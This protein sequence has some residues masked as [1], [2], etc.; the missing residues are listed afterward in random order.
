MNYRFIG[1]S[2]EIAG[3]AALRLYGQSVELPDGVARDAI[4]GGCAL[5]PDRD[6]TELGFTPEELSIYQ[7][8]G[9]RQNAS[10]EFQAKHR[11]ALLALHNLREQLSKG[12]NLTDGKR[13]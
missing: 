5:I 2:S 3:V 13:K 6:F 12:G 4:T 9:P 11:Q 8:P 10:P 1:L 7:H